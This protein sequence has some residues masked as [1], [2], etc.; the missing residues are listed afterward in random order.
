MRFFIVWHFA[1]IDSSYFAKNDGKKKE[2]EKKKKREEKEKEESKERKKFV[3][4]FPCKL[5][6][7]FVFLSPKNVLL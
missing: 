1:I 4:F 7:V 2:K 3:V 6:V 5:K